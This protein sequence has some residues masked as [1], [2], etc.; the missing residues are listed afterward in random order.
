MLTKNDLKQINSLLNPFN[1]ELAKLRKVLDVNTKEITE[2]KDGLRINT[3]STMEIEKKI[4]AA[5]ELRIDVSQFRKQVKD[6]E[7]RISQLEN[8]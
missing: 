5:L 8:L 4:D 7:E 6:H 2:V 3:R 1:K